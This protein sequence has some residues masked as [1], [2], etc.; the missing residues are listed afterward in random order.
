MLEGG[1]KAKEAVAQIEQEVT[2]LSR[3]DHP[4]IVRYAGTQREGGSLF[5]FLEYVPVSGDKC[6]L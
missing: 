3:F 1:S 2:L 6:D 5:I 4:N